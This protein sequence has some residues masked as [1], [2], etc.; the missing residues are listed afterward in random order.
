MK[1]EK[2]LEILKAV[3]P[4]VNFESETALVTNQVLDS[5][6][7]MEIVSRL[8]EE[9]SIEIDMEYMDAAHFDSVDAMLEMIDELS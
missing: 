2:L 8:E 7:T 3:K 1:R 9:F 4:E 5:I 6:D